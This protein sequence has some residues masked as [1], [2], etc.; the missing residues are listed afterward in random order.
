MVHLVIR[1]P[2]LFQF[3][4]QLDTRSYTKCLLLFFVSVPTCPSISFITD[5]ASGSSP[6]L[7]GHNEITKLWCIKEA[8]CL[9]P[10]HIKIK[11]NYTHKWLGCIILFYWAG[12]I[13][14]KKSCKF[15]QLTIHRYQNTMGIISK[16]KREE[17]NRWWV[18]AKIKKQEEETKLDT[19]EKRDPILE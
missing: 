17:K 5:L 11:R 10:S 19:R 3:T 6:G 7:Q 9:L 4:Q 12:Y 1:F 8:K 16:G 18:A 14:E 2:N 15:V 13:T